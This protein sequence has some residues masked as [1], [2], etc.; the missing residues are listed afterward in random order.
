MTALVDV[1][2]VDG[3]ALPYVSGAETALAGTGLDP[4]FDAGWQALATGFAGISLKPLFDALAQTPHTLVHGDYKFAN[5]GSL[6]PTTMGADHPIAKE[7]R[8]IMLDWQDATFGPP[9]LDLGYFLAIEAARLPV[10]KDAVLE[11]YR[12]ELATAG[13]R[14]EARTWE[15]DV[16][17]GL[18][19]GGAMRLLWQKA[20]RTQAADPAICEQAQADLAWWSEQVVRARRWLA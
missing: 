16:A 13:H 8:T 19:A 10:T 18:L 2:L 9:L 11:V 14:P 12:E 7:P 1:C 20:L 6:A 3:L 17:L 5:L 15:R 4:A